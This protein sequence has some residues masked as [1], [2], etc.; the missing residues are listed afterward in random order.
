MASSLLNPTSNLFLKS[1]LLYQRPAAVST[2]RCF[3][4]SCGPRDGRG[5]LVKG[6]T[7]SIEA[8]QAVQTLKRAKRS[9]DPT[10]LS[11]ALQKTFARLIKADLVAALKELLRQDECALAL[12]ALHAVKS[13]YPKPDLSLYADVAAALGRAGD[14]AA[15]DRL[16]ADLEADGSAI[17]C[18]DKKGLG[19]LLTVVINWGSRESTARMYAMMRKSGWGSTCTPDDHIVKVL[20]KGFSR[21]GDVELA[22]EVEKEFGGIMRTKSEISKVQTL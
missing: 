2:T 18:G 10:V 14:G 8:I 16:V 21:F 13:E 12:E 4:I 17:N 7:L 9:P 5:P 3:L 22:K 19:K 1:S 15:I 6:R 11:A 20:I